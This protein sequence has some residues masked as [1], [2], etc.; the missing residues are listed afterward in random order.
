MWFAND[1]DRDTVWIADRHRSKI[2]GRGKGEGFVSARVGD[3]TYVAMY[4]SMVER[5]V[6]AL[7]DIS[8]LLLVAVNF[9]ARVIE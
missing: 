9:N 1:S 4:I 3:G 2:T 5:M 8:V 6:D 7:R